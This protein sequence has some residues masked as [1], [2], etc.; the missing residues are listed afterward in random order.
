[1]ISTLLNERGLLPHTADSF[2]TNS[3]K[4]KN[5]VRITMRDSRC[6]VVRTGEHEKK[7]TF[8]DGRELYRSLGKGGKHEHLPILDREDC[9][10]K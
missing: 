8:V 9:Q 3:Q 6:D 10:G 2:G 5:A 4:N 1:M 7:S